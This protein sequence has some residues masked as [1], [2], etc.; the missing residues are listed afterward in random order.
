M[1]DTCVNPPKLQLSRRGTTIEPRP[2][3]G[4]TTQLLRPRRVHTAP[5]TPRRPPEK[6]T[7]K[8]AKA[9]A[10][11]SRSQWYPATET[12]WF[13]NGKTHIWGPIPPSNRRNGTPATIPHVNP[14]TESPDQRG[15]PM[16]VGRAHVF[17]RNRRMDH[18]LSWRQPK[19]AFQPCH[20]RRARRRH[21]PA[22]RFPPI[23]PSERRTSPDREI[24]MPGSAQGGH[25]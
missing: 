12:E 9:Q 24:K 22:T 8:A 15:R 7:C 2:T 6:P 14:L 25:P 19:L 16:P 18:R 4:P 1:L 3:N 11:A 13:V 10:K 20:R 21:C 5:A 17:R 23:P